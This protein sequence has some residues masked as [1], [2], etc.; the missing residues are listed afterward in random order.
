MALF[1]E[2]LNIKTKTRWKTA[3]AFPHLFLFLLV[4]Y[5]NKTLTRKKP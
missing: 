1:D 3:M 2:A 5:Y 4:N